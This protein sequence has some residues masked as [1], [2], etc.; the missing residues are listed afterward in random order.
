MITPKGSQG[1]AYCTLK[2]TFKDSAKGDAIHSIVDKTILLQGQL[3]R[4]LPWV[5]KS[6]VIQC[7][8]CMRWG[9]HVSACKSLVPYCGLC[10]GPHQTHSHKAYLA[11]GL[12]NSA[13]VVLCCINCTAVKK[14]ANHSA[15]STD[16]PFFKARFSRKDL[17]MLLDTIRANRSRGFKSPFNQRSMTFIDSDIYKDPVITG[18]P[19]GNKEVW[20]DGKIIEVVTTSYKKKD[21]RSVRFSA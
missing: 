5:N 4:T 6:A 2:A 7:N 18:T 17:T 15:T 14:N 12:V 1:A 8:S 20:Q 9:H 19:L 16:C 13:I 10:T 3:H 11:K 21:K